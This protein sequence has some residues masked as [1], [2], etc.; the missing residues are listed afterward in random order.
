MLADNGKPDNSDDSGSVKQR[1]KFQTEQ[2]I[3]LERIGRW[4]N[5]CCQLD[6][7]M[8]NFM[9]TYTIYKHIGNLSQ[10]NNGW[11]K[12]LNY[13]S[14]DDREPVYDIRTWNAEH[15]EYGKGVTITAG[16]M[17]VLKKIL[18]EMKMF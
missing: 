7:G 16:Q 14:W 6:S 1:L 8:E 3:L 17:V 4:I 13:I 18:E 2:A 5:L 12:E 11:T 9:K 10:P 15:T